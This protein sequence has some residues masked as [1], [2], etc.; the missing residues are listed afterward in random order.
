VE[1][2]NEVRAAQAQRGSLGTPLA[3]ARGGA[4]LSGF[5]RCSFS[6]RGVAGRA[7]R[8]AE[9]GAEDAKQTQTGGDVLP[10]EISCD[11]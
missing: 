1:R 7:D 2:A 8:P 6:R 3:G 11:L 5:G 4:P 9:V 10:S